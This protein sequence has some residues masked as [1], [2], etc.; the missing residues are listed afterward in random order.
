MGKSLSKFIIVISAVGIGFRLWSKGMI[1]AEK[2]VIFLVLVVIAAAI[3][4]IWV[5]LILAFAGV[6][7]FT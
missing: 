7:F 4:S 5:K 3:D 2:F 1:N 6:G